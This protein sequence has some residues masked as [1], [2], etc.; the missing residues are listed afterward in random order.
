MDH[1]VKENVNNT[2]VH[3]AARDFVQ[4]SRIGYFGSRVVSDSSQPIHR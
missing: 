4:C 2:T 1:E 3:V